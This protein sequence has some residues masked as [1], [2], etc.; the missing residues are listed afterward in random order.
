[1]SE[2]PLG[3]PFTFEDV[4]L[5]WTVKDV[6]SGDEC[7]T[8]IQ[9]IEDQ[10]PDLATDN[11]IYRDQDRVMF[12]EPSVA[13]D[14]FA[15]LRPS[16]PESMGRFHL[17]GL[18]ERLRFYR[19]KPGQKFAPHMD[20]WFQPDD[21][22]ITLLTVLVYFNADFEGGETRFMEQLEETVVPEPGMAAIF[23]HKVRHEGCEVRSGRKYALRSDV[24]YSLDKAETDPLKLAS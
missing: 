11:P 21:R 15:R 13:A 8:F 18:N 16:L 9:M 22:S 14:L 19:Y 17:R 1:M 3:V 24:I 20:H 10:S 23:Q 12:D 7:R 2:L 5:L 4:D 6:Y